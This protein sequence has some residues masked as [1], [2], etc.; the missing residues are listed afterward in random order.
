MNESIGFT[1]LLARHK[2]AFNLSKRLT[3]TRQVIRG[4]MRVSREAS[5]G[6]LFLSG[7]IREPQTVRRFPGY[8]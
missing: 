7:H 8:P 1:L 6:T 3:L 2:D 4:G 5:C